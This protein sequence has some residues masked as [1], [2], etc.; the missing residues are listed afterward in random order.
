MTNDIRDLAR[1]VEAMGAAGQ[2]TQGQLMVFTCAVA[3]L[4]RSHPDP[5]AF[6]AEFRRFW[7]LSGS[8]HS[9]DAND[10]PGQQ[11]IYELLEILEEAC[12]VPLGARPEH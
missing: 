5:A 2:N 9:N 11:G 10:G 7:Q 8:Q 1:A 12:K 4:V 6:A 3:A